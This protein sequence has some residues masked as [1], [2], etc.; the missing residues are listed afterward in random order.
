MCDV[1]GHYSRPDV[2]RLVVNRN[3]ARRLVEEELS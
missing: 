1:A 2:L 3:P